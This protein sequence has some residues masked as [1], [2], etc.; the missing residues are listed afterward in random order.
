MQRVNKVLFPALSAP[1][2]FDMTIETGYC[3]IPRAIFHY[4][5]SPEIGVLT[6][7]VIV[8]YFDNY[9]WSTGM[10]GDLKLSAYDCLIPPNT[11]PGV[12]RQLLNDVL[13]KLIKDGIF[14]RTKEHQKHC[15]IRLQDTGE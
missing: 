12:S 6:K 14:L 13:D 15:I 5:M 7:K 2:L 8:Y 4:L 9:R 1:R 10:V 3:K 11:F